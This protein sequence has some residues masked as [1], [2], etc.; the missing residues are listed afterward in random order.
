MMD[1]DDD[2]DDGG[3]AMMDSVMMAVKQKNGEK[4]KRMDQGSR[5]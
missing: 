3:D 5:P 1:S 4:T 2:A